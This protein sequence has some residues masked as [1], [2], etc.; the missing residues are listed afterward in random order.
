M[1]T[2]RS[3]A[4]ILF[5][6]TLAGCGLLP[7]KEGAF[8]PNPFVIRSIEIS[9]AWRDKQ[10]MIV[11]HKGNSWV[12]TASD[13][14]KWNSYAAR[15]CNT[16]VAA[17]AAIAREVEQLESRIVVNTEKKKNHQPTA[18]GASDD[19]KKKAADLVA[20]ISKQIISKQIED[21]KSALQQKQAQ[22]KAEEASIT[23]NSECIAA[24]NSIMSVH[25]RVS[26]DACGKH[27]A[28]AQHDAVTTN[29]LLGVA[30]SAA[31]MA[32][33]VVGSGDGPRALAAT[34]GLTNSARSLTNE[35]LYLQRI[36]P[37]ITS[38]IRKNRSDAVKSIM[39]KQKKSTAE[40]SLDMALAEL[41]YLHHAC[42]FA[43]GLELIA[44]SAA[45][46]G[47]ITREALDGQIS[48][49][50]TE[51]TEVQ[52]KIDALPA[53]DSRRSDLTRDRDLLYSRRLQLVLQRTNFLAN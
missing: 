36:A 11:Q 8:G 29:V 47:A 40:Y 44:Q 35:E 52:K 38:G 4:L 23:S 51:L 46:R 7:I 20:S 33:T 5:V 32:A 13:E 1:R 48:T 12:N 6:G 22:L 28:D 31:S 53:G 16:H 17:V 41:N 10:P 2:L 49:L 30:T 19:D 18:V 42:S 25:M 9:D 21:D 45:T 24:R 26:D 43:F 3:C 34:A 39:E 37:L 27:L 15:Q 50:D 14:Y